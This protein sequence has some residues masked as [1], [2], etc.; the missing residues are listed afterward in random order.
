LTSSLG[1][2][3]RAALLGAQLRALVA[4]HDAAAGEGAEVVPF[5]GGAGL[6]TAT[7]IWV[8]LSPVADDRARPS[9]GP[10]LGAILAWATQG[11]TAGRSIDVVVAGAAED[12]APAIA[13]Q[14]ALFA[15]A[16]AVWRI[17]G[18]EL[19]AVAPEGPEPPPEPP[20]AALALL[21]E[22][23]GAGLE[24]IVEHGV[25]RGEIAGLEVAVIV[26]DGSGGEPGAARIEVGV[27]R[28]DREAFALLH[29]DLPPAE[30]MRR[31][32]DTVRRHRRPGAPAHPLNRM[33]PE[34]WLRA[35]LLHDP[36]R[37]P[38]WN[39]APVSGLTARSG[40][41]EAG[42]AFA[43][44]HDAESRSVVLACSVGID[45]ELV[46][47]AADTRAAVDPGARLVLAVPARDA[48]PVTERLAARLI[49]PAEVLPVDGE[50]RREIRD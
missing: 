9:S 35:H 2:E 1:P 26:V 49:D 43:Y 46:P 31:V 38:G 34:R 30:A 11:G 32:A 14:A 39:L 15:P 18:R 10:G 40:V 47:V 8:L 37:L 45:L 3:R 36:G 29:G 25:V 41:A 42:P 33:A 24:V 20:P 44:G 21:D 19:V 27:G 28:N 23:R 48:H 16:P 17:D 12:R 22:L 6:R 4:A 7:S 13:R 50:W 5:A